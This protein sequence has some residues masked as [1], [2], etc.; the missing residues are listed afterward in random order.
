MDMVSC[1]HIQ[2]L[3]NQ[4]PYPEFQPFSTGHYQAKIIRPI[5]YT[6]IHIFRLDYSYRLPFYPDYLSD[7]TG[8]ELFRG[9]L[10][11]QRQLNEG[12]PEFAGGANYC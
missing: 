8:G 10:Y 1:S 3:Y 6:Q 2:N 4:I 9:A 5:S 7:H 12:E 11:A